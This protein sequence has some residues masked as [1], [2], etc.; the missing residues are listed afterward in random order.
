LGPWWDGVRLRFPTLF[1]EH[2]S[3][4]V[5]EGTGSP[6]NGVALSR[7]DRKLI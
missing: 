1:S 7:V 4:G 6:G 2:S 3:R 5:D